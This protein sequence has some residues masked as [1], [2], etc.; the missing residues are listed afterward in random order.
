MGKSD[1]RQGLFLFLFFLPLRG[2]DGN[3]VES[4]DH[5]PSEIELKMKWARFGRVFPPPGYYPDI[6]DIIMTND[7]R[8][9]QR[10]W[11]TRGGVR[12][13]NRIEEA[14][15]DIYLSLISIARLRLV[16][17]TVHLPS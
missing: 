12:V 13:K 17:I 16:F 5:A 4:I 15:W 10:K 1:E 6:S 7:S 2:I 14:G 3:S 9:G 11:L 8:T